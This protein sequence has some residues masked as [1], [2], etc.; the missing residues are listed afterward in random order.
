MFW[1]RIAPLGRLPL[2]LHLRRSME[3]MAHPR[4]LLRRS[5][6]PGWKRSRPESLPPRQRP[7][8]QQR[9][10][11]PHNAPLR[12]GHLH[13]LLLHQSPKS[14]FA[15]NWATSRE[16]VSPWEFTLLSWEMRDWVMARR[17]ERARTRT[18]RK[19]RVTIPISQRRSGLDGGVGLSTLRT[20]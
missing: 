6:C 11:L 7:S 17:M 10:W 18:K 19:S 8:L 2:L 14:A 3:R 4:R 15:Q 12:R 9:V 16:V 20:I 13:P 1:R 5:R